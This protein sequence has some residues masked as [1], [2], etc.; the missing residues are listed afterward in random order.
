MWLRG[1]LAPVCH[2]PPGAECPGPSAMSI[3]S[4]YYAVRDPVTMEVATFLCDGGRCSSDFTCGPNR[5]SAADN[6]LSSHCGH[7]VVRVRSVF[8]INII[9]P[10]VL[11]QQ[12]QPESASGV[13]SKHMERAARQD[14]EGAGADVGGGWYRCHRR[15]WTAQRWRAEGRRAERGR[16]DARPADGVRVSRRRPHGAACVHRR[17]MQLQSWSATRPLD[18]RSRTREW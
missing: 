10:S 18:S 14:Q 16:A 3:S 12:G 4:L 6:P 17:C 11:C 1:T 13:G 2:A 15:T 9:H 5:L 7:E 8:L